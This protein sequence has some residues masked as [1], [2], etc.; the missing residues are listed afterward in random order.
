[1]DI[2]KYSYIDGDKVVETEE[3]K[4]FITPKCNDKKQ[5]FRYLEQK[6]FPFF[7]PMK[8]SFRDSYEVYPYVEDDILP[9]D[10]ALDLIHILSL[11]HIKTTTYQTVVMDNVKELYE[12]VSRQIQD[13][14]DY[15]QKLQDDIENHIYMAPDEALFMKNVS[16][17]YQNFQKSREYLELWYE[18]KKS[19]KE[20]RV[21]FLHKQP[22]LLH[23]VDQK[24]PYFTHWDLSD[25]GYVIYDFLYFY[26]KD[27]MI[28]E[29]NPLFQIYQSKYKFTEDEM[30]LFFCLLLLD[31]KVEFISSNHYESTIVVQRH[32]SYAKK[33]SQFILEQNQK[34]EETDQ[35]KFNE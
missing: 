26:K 8:N 5:V 34:D 7:L 17:F 18:M 2:Y 31:E 23:F 4:F 29:M 25:K 27:Y 14:I 9:A 30:L 10:K 20:E 35:S 19:Q 32:V 28:V 24:T 11:L 21:V 1:M 16:L 12:S 6:D 13:K 15:Y 3:G 33:V 22:C